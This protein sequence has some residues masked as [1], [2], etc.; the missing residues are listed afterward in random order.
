MAALLLKGG[1]EVT[2]QL[3]EGES[4]RIRA[5]T[6]MRGAQR[7]ITGWLRDQGYAPAGRWETVGTTSARQFREVAP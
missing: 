6:S 1:C 2:C 7:E 5:S 4:P 3:S